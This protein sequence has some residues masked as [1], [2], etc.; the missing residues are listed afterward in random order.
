MKVSRLGK[1]LDMEKLFELERSKNSNV[2]WRVATVWLSLQGTKEEKSIANTWT[3]IVDPLMTNK[4]ASR[5]TKKV[6]RLVEGLDFFKIWQT[7]I[8][9]ELSKSKDD[10]SE[11]TTSNSDGEKASDSDKPSKDENNKASSHHDDPSNNNNIKASDRSNNDPSSKTR[12]EAFYQRAALIW[13]ALQGTPAEISVVKAMAMLDPAMGIEEADDSK[14]KVV[15]LGKKVE[16]ENLFKKARFNNVNV[17]WRV[18]TVWL[19]LVGTASIRK[20]IVNIWTMIDPLMCEEE[21]SKNKMKVSR[22]GTGLDFGKLWKIAIRCDN[23]SL[24]SKTPAKVNEAS[25]DIDSENSCNK[26]SD[27]IKASDSRNSNSTLPQILD[28][29]TLFWS[30]AVVWTSLLDTPGA[31]SLTE[32]IQIWCFLR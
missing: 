11:D 6:T 19:S 7:A 18:A 16:L 31:V 12:D 23:P 27:S 5:S 22:L 1:K 25:E 17:P 9:I 14:I 2:P 21:A 20:L 4:Y 30:A 8:G 24:S 29:D 32:A 3:M 28:N 10:V 26:A 13:Q 15:K